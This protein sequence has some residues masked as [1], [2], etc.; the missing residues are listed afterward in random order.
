MTRDLR[1]MALSLFIW[2]FGEGL[3]F[4]FQPLY[5]EQL[6]ADVLQIGGVLGLSG[7]GMALFHIPAG[8]LADRYGR[9]R[10]MVIAWI[11]STVAA[12]IMFLAPVLGI[13]VIGL[14][15]YNFTIAVVMAP[16]SSYISAA[17]GRW[18]VARALTAVFAW[19]NVGVTLSPLIGGQ[20][21]ERLGLRTVFGI[22]AG[23]F[24]LS[25][26][27][28]FFMTSQP[29]EPAEGDGSRYR[30]LLSNRPFAGFVGVVFVVT[31]GLY[32]SW[33]LTPLFLE[34][35]RGAALSEIGLFGT[36]NALGATVF[37]LALGRLRARLAFP[38]AQGIVA[39]SVLLLWGGMGI[40]WFAMG[41]F[42]AAAYRTSRHVVMDLADDF[43]QRAEMGMAY[44]LVE[45]LSDLA[46]VFASLVAGLLYRVAPALPFPVSLAWIGLGLLLTLRFMPRPER[47]FP[48]QPA[49]LQ[50]RGP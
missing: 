49:R 29:I 16:A 43:V 30:A 48:F 40:P 4:Y 50:H 24:A 10:M 26:V 15:L 23:L 44:G 12:W 8:V 20:L 19:F 13:F 2:G 41:Y 35:V 34:S 18:S 22:G 17:R 37:H 39:G 3:F 32:L 6:G 25:S 33:P 1:L 9:K 46:V 47:R 5:L 38:L 28:I 14:A 11:L 42:L 36:L 27:V 7:V 31:F 45:S 21:G